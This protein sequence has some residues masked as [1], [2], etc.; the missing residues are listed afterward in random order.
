MRP[1]LQSRVA[2]TSG[3]VAHACT[4]GSATQCHPWLHREFELEASLCAARA[5]LKEVG[6][7]RG[8]FWIQIFLETP[9]AEEGYRSL[10]WLLLSAL[11]L[12]FPWEEETPERTRRCGI[13]RPVSPKPHSATCC[14]LWVIAAACLEPVLWFLPNLPHFPMMICY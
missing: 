2:H 4:R 14:L 12:W 8:V 9:T 6:G 13:W 5:Y 7:G 1:C 3:E 10:G 11:S